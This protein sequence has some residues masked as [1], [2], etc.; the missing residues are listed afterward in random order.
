MDLTVE[1][2]FFEWHCAS[3]SRWVQQ[4][5]LDRGVWWVQSVGPE[6]DAAERLNSKC[7]RLMCPVEISGVLWLT[8]GFSTWSSC[9]LHR[10]HQLRMWNWCFLGCGFFKNSSKLS[11]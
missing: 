11:I 4:T 10:P 2:G 5:T 7:G 9:E 8:L 1:S 6:L 3:V